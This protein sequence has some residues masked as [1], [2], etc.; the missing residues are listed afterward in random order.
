VFADMVIPFVP[1]ENHEFVMQEN[2][3]A[4]NRKIRYWCGQTER[5]HPVKATIGD[6]TPPAGDVIDLEN[7]KGKPKGDGM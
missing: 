3:V 5:R 1:S 7:R 2:I 4:V 6:S